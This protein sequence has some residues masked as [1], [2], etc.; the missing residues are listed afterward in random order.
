MF[1]IWMVFAGK[2]LIDPKKYLIKKA[3]SVVVH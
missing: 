1:S 2:G 3:F